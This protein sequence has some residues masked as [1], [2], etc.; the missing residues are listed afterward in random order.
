M[1]VLKP[2][3][4]AIFFI[5]SGCSSVNKELPKPSLGDIKTIQPAIQYESINIS[6]VDL[7]KSYKELLKIAKEEEKDDGTT[8]KRLSDISLEHSI[9]DLL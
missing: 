9:D 8:L 5:L 1:N 6:Q 7:I 3:I 2:S 4:I